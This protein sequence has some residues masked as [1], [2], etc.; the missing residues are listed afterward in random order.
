MG[1]LGCGGCSTTCTPLDTGP[2]RTRW[3]SRCSP[4]HPT[5]SS[6]DSDIP[7]VRTD[8]EPWACSQDCCGSCRADPGGRSCRSGDWWSLLAGKEARGRRRPLD[9]GRAAPSTRGATA[10]CF[11]C[12]PGESQVAEVTDGSLADFRRRY[13]HEF[14]VP[15]PGK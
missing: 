8:Q 6:L 15:R 9:L 3:N 12:R 2:P 5:P 13:H 1:W 7:A 4:S 14:R 11:L 10:R